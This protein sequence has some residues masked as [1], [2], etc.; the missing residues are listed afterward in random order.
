VSFVVDASTALSWCFE[1]ESSVY[2]DKVLSL[3]AS[4]TAVVPVIWPLEVTNAL[5][6]GERRG[7]LTEAKTARFVQLL[8][9]LPIEIDA[10]PRL[11]GFS[12]VLSLARSHRL[13]SYD[14][15][16]IELAERRGLKLA[17]LDAR[18]RE[19]AAG[20]GVGLLD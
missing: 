15:S 4:D 5:V 2:S 11:V 12:G 14:A 8:G 7:R 17:T 1:D 9:Q 18:L 13:S 16:Y 19:A 10:P 6:V 20:A 3:L